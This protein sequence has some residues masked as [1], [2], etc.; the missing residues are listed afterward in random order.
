MEKIISKTPGARAP[1][2]ATSTGF[3]KEAGRSHANSFLT[4]N[5]PRKTLGPA[6]V[7]KVEEGMPQPGD[8]KWSKERLEQLMQWPQYRPV[9]DKSVM[10]PM[11]LRSNS[12]M[13]M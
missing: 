3:A 11:H 7:I 13:T 5:S 2:I 6:F 12:P 10:L 1:F 4:T 8:V 9:R